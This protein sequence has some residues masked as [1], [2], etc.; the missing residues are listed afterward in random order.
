MFPQDIKKKTFTKTLKGYNPAE[1]DE[2]ISYVL[3]KYSDACQE[4]AELEKKLAVA[5][6]KLE[7]A[8]SEEN[9][10]SAT[11]VN[12]QKMADA[13]VADAKTKAD[14]IRTTVSE[15]CEKIISAYVEKVKTERDKLAKVEE[16]AIS[17]KDSLYEAYKEHIAMIDN[18]MPDE[19]PTPY[20]SDEELELKAVELAQEQINSNNGESAAS[21]SKDEEVAE[22]SEN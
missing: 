21:E 8:K 3:S 9:M 2:Y 16:A 18:I 4:Y 15:T 17:F 10:I 11:I 1:V 22:T 20:L 19:E 13:I 12:A 6:E 14:D 5:L 7:L